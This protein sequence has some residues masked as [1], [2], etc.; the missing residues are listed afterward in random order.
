MPEITW[1]KVLHEK[2][3]PKD[4]RLLLIGTPRQL[5]MANL[6]PDIVVGHRNE[7]RSAFVRSKS[8]IRETARGPNSMSDGGQSSPAFQ[9]ASSL[10]S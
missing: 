8:L 5:A 9:M 4:R 1:H 3:I 10:E 2:H 7:R 6:T